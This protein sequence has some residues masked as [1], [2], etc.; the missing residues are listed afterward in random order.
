[1]DEEKHSTI[2]EL[3]VEDWRYLEMIGIKPNDQ[4]ERDELTLNVFKNALTKEKKQYF[5]SWREEIQVCYLKIA[6]CHLVV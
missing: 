4:S 2:F 3:N 1:M 6:N 5:V